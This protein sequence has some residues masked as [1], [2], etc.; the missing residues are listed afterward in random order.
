[1]YHPKFSGEWR[2]SGTLPGSVAH[3]PS[4]SC[5]AKVRLTEGLPTQALPSC[6]STSWSAVQWSSGWCSETYAAHFCLGKAL[7]Q[8]CSRLSSE[9]C[10]LS[11]WGPP[12]GGAFPLE[13]RIVRIPILPCRVLLLV[14]L[15]L[16]PP[17]ICVRSA[18]ILCRW[19]WCNFDAV[20]R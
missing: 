10:I 1:M 12:A 5:F 7:L 8:T 15:V 9:S 11:W 14:L 13:F 17:L 6:K 16:C 18:C 20:A 19:R 2:P 3:S 4:S